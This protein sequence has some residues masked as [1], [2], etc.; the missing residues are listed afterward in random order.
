MS[1]AG[2]LQDVVE[3]VRGVDDALE[4]LVEVQLRRRSAVRDETTGRRE[5]L[6][7]VTVEA[8]VQGFSRR[9]ISSEN[10]IETAKH[11]VTLYG[12]RVDT[13]DQLSWDDEDHTV[14]HVDGLVKDTDGSLRY[15]SKVLTN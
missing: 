2:W 7:A 13:G 9:I 6:A 15:L 14:L 11:Q 1:N 3:A 8:K 12:E 5:F 4:L 10:T